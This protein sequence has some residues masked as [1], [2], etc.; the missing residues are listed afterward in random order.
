VKARQAF[1]RGADLGDPEALKN[2]AVMYKEGW[3]GPADPDQA[4]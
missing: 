2:L 1:Q 3:G 4:L